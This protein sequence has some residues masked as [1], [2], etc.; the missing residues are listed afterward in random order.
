VPRI[1]VRNSTIPSLSQYSWL[2]LKEASAT[3]DSSQQ[4]L[5]SPSMRRPIRVKKF[6][7]FLLFHLFCGARPRAVI[8]RMLSAWPFLK[9]HSFVAERCSERPGAVKGAFF[10]AKRTLY[11]EDRSERIPLE[12]I[13][14]SP[15]SLQIVRL[16]TRKP[17]L[18][19]AKPPLSPPFHPHSC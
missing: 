14:D 16:P 6:F 12:G 17:V 19:S 5:P 8:G 1:F 7:L 18:G 2:G 9:K 3:S 10:A 15:D 13:A 4:L 11:G